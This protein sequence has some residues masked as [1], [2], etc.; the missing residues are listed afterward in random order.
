MSEINLPPDSMYNY[1]TEEYELRSA[2]QTDAEARQF[3]PQGAARSLYTLLREHK[4]LGI[5]EAMVRAL[6]GE[7]DS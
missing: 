4:G 3:L 7:V 5:L 6:G 1:D 2:P